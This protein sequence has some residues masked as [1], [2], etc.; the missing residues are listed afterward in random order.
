M[1]KKEILTALLDSKKV[2][3]LKVLLTTNEELYLNEIA[4]KSKVP[5]TSTFRLLRY[6]ENLNLIEKKVWK[7]S[8]TYSCK[9]N[10]KTS[11][12]KEL[13][14]EEFDGINTFLE[15]VKNLSEIKQVIAHG[16]R[17]KNKAN[18]LL[19]GENIDQNKIEDITQEIKNKGFDLSYVCLTNSQYHQMAKMGLYSGEKK[20]LSD[21]QS[22]KP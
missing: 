6:F 16:K 5:I 20:V 14:I 11:Y 4:K 1:V 3:V 21:S 19:I 8:K 22:V 9:N 2:A 13:F 17:T 7:T 12:L 18:L 10:E 15:A